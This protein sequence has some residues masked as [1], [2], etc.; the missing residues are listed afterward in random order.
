MDVGLAGK[1][2]TCRGLRSVVGRQVCDKAID[3][4]IADTNVGFFVASI[5]R[6]PRPVVGGH[7]ESA[8]AAGLDAGGARRGRS[9][10]NTELDRC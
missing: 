6:S 9:A 7:P 3:H 5:T 8:G 1:F 2:V 4:A 10:G